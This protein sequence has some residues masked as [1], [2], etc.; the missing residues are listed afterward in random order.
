MGPEEAS[1]LRF[2]AVWM[3]R[4]GDLGWPGSVVGSPLLAWP[5]RRELGMPGADVAADAAQERRVTERIAASGVEVAFSYA[6]QAADGRQRPSPLMNG[7]GLEEADAVSGTENGD[8][9]VALEVVEDAASF[10][11]LREG[12]VQG[13]MSVLKA[14]AACAFHAFAE[15]RLFATDL[16]TR[17]PGMSASERGI[18]VHGML[19]R[20]WDEVETQAALKAK[21][22]AEREALL[23]SAVDATLV[24]MKIGMDGATAWDKAYLDAQR[25]RLV[26]LGTQWLDLEA[27]RATP[28]AVARRESEEKNVT[29]GP[30][31]LT[32]RLDRVDAT[33]D[34]AVLID[35]K[36]GPVSSSAWQGERPDE[37]QLPLYAVLA[38]EMRLHAVAFGMVRAGDGM[39][40]AGYAEK[41]GTLTAKPFTLERSSLEEQVEQW[42]GVLEGLATS[43]A[44]GNA[45]VS[46]K[47]YP[48]TCQYCAHQLICRLDVASRN[49]ENDE[50]SE[51]AQAAEEERG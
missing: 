24:K 18:A 50:E 7:L 23:L 38:G 26:R 8:V 33:E 28:F 39:R 32:L 13:G 12:L 43:F 51:L 34:G 3:L 14:Q 48:A 29:I 19:E 36:T 10:P 11:P 40:L 4:A 17:E 5:L 20:F 41:P 45:R 42:R 22:T 44:E 31:R 37:P 49:A 16:E 9:P 47:A 1:G 15:Y 35:Y 25:W 21:T 6:R 27:A 30:L 46:P 2:D